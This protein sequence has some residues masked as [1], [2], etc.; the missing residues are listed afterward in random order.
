MQSE[1]SVCRRCNA[2][3]EISNL[4]T[5]SLA[6]FRTVLGR[7]PTEEEVRWAAICRE[8]GRSRLVPRFRLDLVLGAI[9]AR[10]KPG[11]QVMVEAWKRVLA[12]S[13]PWV[14]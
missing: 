3:M 13:F 10:E 12:G 5:P 14:R 9:R 6:A 11:R 7:F 1:I 2:A 4:L 8:H